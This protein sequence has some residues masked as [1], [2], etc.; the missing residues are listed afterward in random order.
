MEALTI[1]QNIP[2]ASVLV[3]SVFVFFFLYPYTQYLLDRRG[4]FQILH[5]YK[6]TEMQVS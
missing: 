3:A 4:K 2:Y 6:T 1:S 5:V